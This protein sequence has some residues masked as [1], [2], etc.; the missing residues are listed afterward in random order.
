MELY[1]LRHGIATEPG[2]WRGS[3][4]DRPL[5]VEGQTR[6]ASEAKSIAKLGLD[7]DCIITSPLLRAKQTAEIV[8]RQMQI[9]DRV[10]EDARLGPDFTL[11]LLA[12]VLSQR[13]KAKAIML[14][15]HEPTLARTIGG[16]VGGVRIDLKKGALALVKLSDPRSLK[17]QLVWL[18]PPKVLIEYARVINDVAL[19]AGT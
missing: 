15:G 8:A 4:F 2:E 6:M 17:G 18:V 13:A 5:T 9:G 16:L 19:R 3:D 7:L 11:D 1:F 14:V 12:A 10:V